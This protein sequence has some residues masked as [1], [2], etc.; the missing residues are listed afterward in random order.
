MSYV[1]TPPPRQLSQQ[2]TLDSLDH[3]KNLFRN[4]YRRDSGFKQFLTQGCTWDYKQ[5]HYGL[6]EKDGQAPEERAE[7]LSDFLNN[8]AGFLP[9]SYLTKKI[10]EDTT[11]LQD[12][13]NQIY[14]HYNVLVSPITFLDFEALKKEPVE[15]Y[16]QFY[17]RLL[18]HVRLHLAPTGAKVENV[19]NTSNDVLTISLMNL[20]TIQWLRKCS[21]SL[22]DIVKTEYSTELRNGEQIAALVPRIAQNIDSLL[23]RHASAS[24]NVVSQVEQASHIKVQQIQNARETFIRH[25]GKPRF[26]NS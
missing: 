24:V 1:K 12:C 13:W 6:Q 14:E 7:N 11:C 10:V 8:L 21:P 25:K 4:Y 9:N 15:N 19:T 5:L 2:E 3:W 20:V 22:L 26:Q 23:A 17:E 18:Q 16:R